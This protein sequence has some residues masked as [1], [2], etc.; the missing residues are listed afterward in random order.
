M[1][2][3]PIIYDWDYGDV[4]P[5]ETGDYVR[6][7]DFERLLDYTVE[8]IRRSPRFDWVNASDLREA[9]MQDIENWRKQKDIPGV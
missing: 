5:L 9:V 7:E 6:Y 2:E 3:W 4:T 1:I 8:M